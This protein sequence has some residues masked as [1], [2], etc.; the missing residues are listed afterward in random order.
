VI[1]AAGAADASEM[2]I[3]IPSSSFKE[4]AGNSKVESLTIKTP[5]GSIALDKVAK[6]PLKQ[7]NKSIFKGS[8]S[9]VK[10][11]GHGLI[12]IKAIDIFKGTPVYLPAL[13]TFILDF[14]SYKKKQND[15]SQ[16]QYY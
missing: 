1:D 3:A 9:A 15:D 2:E 8:L 5:M 10:R 16:Q 7:P 13:F 14:I 11:F 4:I 6:E 12:H